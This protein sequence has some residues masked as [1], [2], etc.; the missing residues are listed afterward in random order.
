M[1]MSAAG[2]E[3]SS[4]PPSIARPPWSKSTP[5]ALVPSVTSTVVP[6]PTQATSLD[7]GVLPVDQFEAVCHSPPEGPS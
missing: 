6:G 4:D 7:V 5:A 3:S 2:L 1:L